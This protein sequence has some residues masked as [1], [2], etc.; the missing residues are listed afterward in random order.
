MAGILPRLDVL[1]RPPATREL[2][3]AESPRPDLPASR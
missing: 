2:I 1:P 3:G